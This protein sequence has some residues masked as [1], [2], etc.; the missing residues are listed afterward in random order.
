MGDIQLPPEDRKEEENNVR[1]LRKL[2]MKE[3][4]AGEGKW[5]DD[6]KSKELYKSAL[7]GIKNNLLARYKMGKLWAEVLEHG[8]EEELEKVLQHVE[9]NMKKEMGP[10]Y[11][12]YPEKPTLR[13]AKRYIYFARAVEAQISSP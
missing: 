9:A 6:P 4:L 3:S 13:N 5:L 11:E 8:G 1:I 10:L 7:E 12:V 2:V